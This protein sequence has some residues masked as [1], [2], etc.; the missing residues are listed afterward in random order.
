[1]MRNYENTTIEVSFQKEMVVIDLNGNNKLSY[2]NLLIK[3]YAL[4]IQS[5]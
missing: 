4:N 1:M 2:S 5:I 3:L